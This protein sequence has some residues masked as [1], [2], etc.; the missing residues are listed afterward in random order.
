MPLAASR[1]QFP[2]HGRRLLLALEL[3]YEFQMLSNSIQIYSFGRA[4]SMPRPQVYVYLRL[5]DQV[6]MPVSV[7]VVQ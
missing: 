7:T 3:H 4:R 2:A 5:A 6:S 1:V